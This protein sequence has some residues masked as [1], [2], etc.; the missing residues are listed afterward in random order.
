MYSDEDKSLGE[1]TCPMCGRIFCAPRPESWAWCKRIEGKKV[2]YCRYSCMRK[3]EN[4]E[5]PAENPGKKPDAER[6]RQ[7]MDMLD[8]GKNVLE[9]Q[10]ALGVSRQ[11]VNHYQRVLR[12]AME[13]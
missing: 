13:D 4:G 11:L 2:Y 9:I 6:A 7:I 1:R 10:R 5:K 8:R 12:E 3:A